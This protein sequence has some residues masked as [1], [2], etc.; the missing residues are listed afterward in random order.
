ME[1]KKEMKKAYD[2]ERTEERKV[3]FKEANKEAKRAVAQARAAALQGMSE[4]L[5]TKEGQRKI[6]KIAKERNRAT[7]DLT[8]AKQIKDKNDKILT[9][10]D[11]IRMRWREYYEELLNQ[12]NPRI[13][14]GTGVGMEGEVDPI[15]EAEV[16]EALKKM[17]KM[18]RGWARPDTSQGM[19]ELGRRRDKT[20]DGIPEFGD[21]KRDNPE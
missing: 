6:Y 21:G 14:R 12:E 13:R 17:K 7:K 1:K 19:E 2:K 16:R 20:V 5:E 11:K 15:R 4:E 3:L 18:E 8:L 10:P 9:D